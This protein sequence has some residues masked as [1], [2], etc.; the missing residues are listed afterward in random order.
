MQ[1]VAS[2]KLAT[3]I[4]ESLGLDPDM[5]ISIELVCKPGELPLVQVL[6]LLTTDMSDDLCE[7]LR[8]YSLQ[9]IGERE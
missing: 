7:V 1:N 9:P 2:V 5:T 3:A 6:Q 8:K 4:A